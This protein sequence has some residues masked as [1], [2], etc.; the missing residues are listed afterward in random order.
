MSTILVEET[1]DIQY[2]TQSENS[3]HADQYDTQSENIKVY[4]N[5]TSSS[6]YISILKRW[7]PWILLIIIIIIV[8][9]C[10]YRYF[11][12]PK[13]QNVDVEFFSMYR[14]FY[15]HPRSLWLSNDPFVLKENLHLHF[16]SVLGDGNV[17]LRNSV[18]KSLYGYNLN[19]FSSISILLVCI[20]FV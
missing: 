19:K 8:I 3:T 13:N 6:K 15:G 9:W 16:V 20:A 12:A 14:E 7:V 5:L 1:S 11:T 2:D 10:L 18:C 4:K 17:Y